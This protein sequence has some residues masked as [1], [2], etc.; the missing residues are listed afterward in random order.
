[1]TGSWFTWIVAVLLVTTT[2]CIGDST[3]TCG[4]GTC[5]ASESCDSCPSDCGACSACG[6][7][8]C[9]AGESC[10]TCPADCGA[11]RTC[12]DRLCGPDGHGGSCGSCAT[13]QQCTS[14]GACI[15]GPRC[16][17]GACNGTETCATCTMDCGPC[18]T[19]CGDHVC[20][21]GETCANCPM[22]CGTCSASC[23]T[24]STAMT[25]TGGNV[26]ERR[27]CDG[28][29]VCVPTTGTNCT[30]VIDSVGEMHA[31]PPVP[32]YG[33]CAS[34]PQCGNWRLAYCA[35]YAMGGSFCTVP[36]TQNSECTPPPV[37]FPNT[38]A[39][40]DTGGHQCYLHC[41]GPGTCPYSMTCLRLMD[42]SY[43]FCA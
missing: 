20:T 31:C 34:N 41:A 1:M 33:G 10:S 17:D 11:C 5:A 26:C 39:V 28:A 13:G 2:A 3:P 42:G 16:G 24:C 43:G 18:P 29:T 38:S 9:G 15:A 12:G 23:Q 8:A 22:D 4:D 25:C 30:T 7:G 19:S 6:D 35:H 36:C 37:G 27:L 14:A 32:T 40:C 21:T